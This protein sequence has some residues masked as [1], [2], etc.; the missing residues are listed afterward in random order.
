MPPSRQSNSAAPSVY[1]ASHSHSQSTGSHGPSLTLTLWLHDVLQG[2]QEAWLN[3]DLFPPGT[4]NPGDIVE[5][6]Q[7]YTSGGTRKGGS[8]S[9][10]EGGASSSAEGGRLESGDDEGTGAESR[11]RGSVVM[12]RNKSDGGGGSTESQVISGEGRFL[13]VVREMDREVWLK[14]PK[15]QVSIPPREVIHYW[16]YSLTVA[17][18]KYTD[19]S[20]AARSQSVWLPISQ[21][22]HRHSCGC[23]QLCVCVCC[24]YAHNAPRC[25]E[26]STKP[27]ILKSAS[28]IS[29]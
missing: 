19:F 16:N 2:K 1:Q 7:A 20:G 22:R 3:Y 6:R 18:P 4:C 28:A 26:S 23:S 10:G 24:F 11:G 29:T 25:K 14:Q 15:M 21:C 8:H 27:P 9:A 17:S 12:K 13:F 5:V